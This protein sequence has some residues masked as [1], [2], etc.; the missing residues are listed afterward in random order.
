MSCLPFKTYINKLTTFFSS[1]SPVQF[2][3]LS[4]SGD[5]I[6]SSSWTEVCV[7]N[8]RNAELHC[9]LRLLD[10]SFFFGFS[11][12]SDGL[13]LSKCYGDNRV[14]LWRIN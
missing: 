10:H 1:Q 4:S 13:A 14:L 5:W 12:V 6:V 9:E 11:P 3:A 8:A 2:F 7:W